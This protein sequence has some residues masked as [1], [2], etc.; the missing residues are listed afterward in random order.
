M[1]RGNKINVKLFNAVRH[2]VGRPN[3][4]LTE[5]ELI[6]ANT[7]R[8]AARLGRLWT[9][10][11]ILFTLISIVATWLVDR[12]AALAVMV[13]GSIAAAIS[14]ARAAILER[15]VSDL[16]PRMWDFGNTVEIY[17]RPGDFVG[18]RV[19]LE[20]TKWKHAQKQYDF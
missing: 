3:I 18:L 11:I 12:Y 7:A 17:L 2:E 9:N 19:G 16:V 4:Y 20:Y 14:A 1:L 15:T 13:I 6:R 8:E 5:S 10:R